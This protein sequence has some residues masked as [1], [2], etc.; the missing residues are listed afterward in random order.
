MYLSKNTVIDY[1]LFVVINPKT[2]K[3]RIG[4]I[5]YV[6]QYTLDKQLESFMKETISK[7]EPTIINPEDYKKRFRIAMDKYFIALIPDKDED[8][9]STVISKYGQ[10]KWFTKQSNWNF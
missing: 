2:R 9:R 10:I 6:Q 4:I 3:I 8:L 7:E 1:S 5:D